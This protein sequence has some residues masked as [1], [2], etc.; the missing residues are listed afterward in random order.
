MKAT[1][2]FLLL[3]LCLLAATSTMVRSPKAA[4]VPIRGGWTTLAPMPAARQE[5]STAVLDGKIYAIAGFTGSGDSTSNVYV[6]T[7]ETNTWAEAAPLPIANNHNA[8]AVA[9]GKLYAFGGV[10]NRCF[11]Y[12]PQNNQWTEAAPMRFQHANTAAVGV[13]NN[14]IYVAGGN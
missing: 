12:D 1:T 8:A 11:V 4:Q 2:M 3:I 7:V 14:K 13:I 10:S 5:L 6:Y 9:A